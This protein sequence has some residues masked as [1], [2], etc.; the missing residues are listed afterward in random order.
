MLSG[1]KGGGLRRP[2]S[3]GDKVSGKTE[4]RNILASPNSATRDPKRDPRN[5]GQTGHNNFF[6]W[7][8]S[9][10]FLFSSTAGWLCQRERLHV[11]VHV[12]PTLPFPQPGA[13]SSL[14]SRRHLAI[15]RGI[16]GCDDSGGM[17]LALV[18]RGLGCHWPSYVHRTA[19]HSKE[20]SDP[21]MSTVLR[22]RNN[23]L[24]YLALRLCQVLML[25]A[26]Y[27]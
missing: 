15:S 12:F 16:L 14:P 13:Y 5:V 1:T 22:L 19:S 9:S 4:P 26:S 27:A 3:I 8:R 18:D 25:N 24:H 11:E 20:L 7:L 2:P 23:V 17:L 10:P 6:L 21:K